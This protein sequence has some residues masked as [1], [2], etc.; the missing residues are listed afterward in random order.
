[1]Q[2]CHSLT[3]KWYDRLRELIDVEIKSYQCRK[4][5][6]DGQ[7]EQRYYEREEHIKKV[8]DQHLKNVEGKVLFNMGSYH[9]QKQRIM[10]SH[11]VWTGEY[12]SKI[13]DY[14][15]NDT[16]CLVIDFARGTNRKGS[17]DLKD[18]KMKNNLYKVIVEETNDQAGFLSYDDPVFTN[19]DIAYF[20]SKRFDPISPK[21]VWDGVLMLPH[22]TFD[23]RYQG[24]YIMTYRTRMQRS[25]FIII[26]L[27]ILNIDALLTALRRNN[28]EKSSG[29]YDLLVLGIIVFN[30]SEAAFWVSISM[31]FIPYIY[32]YFKASYSYRILNVTNSNFAEMQS[33]I[34]KY[35]VQ[36]HNIELEYNKNSIR[37][38]GSRPHKRELKPMLQAINH[39]LRTNGKTS[40]ESMLWAAAFFLIS[41]LVFVLG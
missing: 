18:I 39:Y 26:F 41:V 2:H 11:L 28:I 25:I 35:V 5:I 34:K 29:F 30:R 3:N 23:Q 13:S 36:D 31:V 8:V 21:A 1:M 9:I 40:I 24:S 27:I 15:K 12:L 6:A 32:R 22:S 16:Y 7:V 17:F 10:G 20:S 19:Q 33:I 14:A 37:L 38:K 4:L